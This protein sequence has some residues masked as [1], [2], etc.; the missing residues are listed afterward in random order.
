MRAVIDMD[1]VASDKLGN[2]VGLGILLYVH[3]TYEVRL[4]IIEHVTI[5]LNMFNLPSIT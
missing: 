5:L 2:L 4:T 1:Y 3:F